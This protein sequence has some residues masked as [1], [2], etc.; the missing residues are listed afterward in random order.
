MRMNALG[1]LLTLAAFAVGAS[2]S[3]A[4]LSGTL[5]QVSFQ[6]PI[7]GGPVN[8]SLYLPEGYAEGTDD[9]PVVYHLHGLGG[10]HLGG[11][12]TTLGASY[13][14]ARAAGLIGPAI[15]VFANGYTD[16][17]WADSANSN[18][19]KPAETNV[20][21]ELVPYI[22]AHYRTA[23]HR[24]GRVIHGFSM[25]GFGTQKFAAKFPGLFSVSVNYDGAMLTWERLE[26]FHPVQA[27]DIFDNDEAYFDQYSPW[28]WSTQNAAQLATGTAMRMVVGA[29]EASNRE[30][31][32][33]LQGL[34]IPVDYVE[35]DQPHAL[36]ALLGVQG[37]QSWAFIQAH[38]D[39]TPCAADW[40]ASGVVN[41]ADV[42]MFINDWFVDQVKGT[43]VADF[44]ANGVTNSTD[45]SAFIN[46]WFED[47][48]NGCG[49]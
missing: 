46:R 17:F 8:F 14:A 13:E 31:H 47:L 28:H 34:G 15:I 6:G 24:G 9:L 40:D 22:D 33:H 19:P 4:Q 42:S 32:D 26:Q 37:A 2:G 21:L 16:S 36:G 23:A 12:L 35:T 27:Q 44:D 11:Q 10:S 7:T 43:L 49:G 1:R 48:E 39:L 3:H 25:G 5:Q 41:S 20:A 45:V 29:L 18:P 30:F 38:L